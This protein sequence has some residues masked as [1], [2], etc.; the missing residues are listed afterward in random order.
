M[1]DAIVV[2]AGPAGMVCAMH[3][4]K[5]GLS[6]KVLEAEPEIPKTLRGSTFHPSSLDML[7]TAFG[8][9]TPLID[10]GLIAHQCHPEQI[11]PTG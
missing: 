5:A 11:K 6:I 3:L 4:A 1:N 8:A 10:Q 2:G 7:E 9:A